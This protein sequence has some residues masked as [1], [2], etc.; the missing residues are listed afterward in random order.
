MLVKRGV[1]LLAYIRKH[2]HGRKVCCSSCVNG[3]VLHGWFPSRLRSPLRGQLLLYVPPDSTSKNST[4]CSGRF[5]F[6]GCKKNQRI[7]PYAAL[8]DYLITEMKGVCC[9]VGSESLNIIQV[10]LNV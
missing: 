6:C 8:I 7:F 3:T 4:L 2:I 9:A 5:F 1:L 10:K